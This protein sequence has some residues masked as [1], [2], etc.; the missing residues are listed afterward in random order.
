MEFWVTGL[1]F[2]M[3]LNQKGSLPIQLII[4]MKVHSVSEITLTKVYSIFG[5]M[6]ILKRDTSL[7]LLELS[8]TCKLGS[9][10]L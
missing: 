10:N 4:T 6:R 1:E 3:L 7:I 8:R 9:R 2:P 5:S